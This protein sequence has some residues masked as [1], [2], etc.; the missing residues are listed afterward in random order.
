M[1]KIAA[2]NLRAPTAGVETPTV[3]PVRGSARALAN[4][5]G[6]GTIALRNSFGISSTTDVGTG[7]YTF[8]FSAAM[9]STDY[10]QMVDG[11]F[12][13][14]WQFTGDRTT[15]ASASSAHF[16]FLSNGANADCAQAMIAI[17]GQLA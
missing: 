13:A 14:G 12:N 11:D 16:R 3:Y 6:T 10:Y 15:L 8:A 7:A 4:L 2:D 1:S 17:F 5:N 9:S